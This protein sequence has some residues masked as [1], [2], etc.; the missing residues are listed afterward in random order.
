MPRCPDAQNVCT[1]TLSP[2]QSC[3]AAP[4]TDFVR[5]LV[6][7]PFLACSQQALRTICACSAQCCC[8]QVL[9]DACAYRLAQPS[10][11]P[12]GLYKQNAW[13]T[14]MLRDNSTH[15]QLSGLAAYEEKGSAVAELLR[16]LAHMHMQLADDLRIRPKAGNMQ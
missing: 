15:Q 10:P 11:I 16:Q 2:V 7:V 13:N 9:Q 4:K 8:V 12:A 6:P 5:T 3:L 1:A 14:C